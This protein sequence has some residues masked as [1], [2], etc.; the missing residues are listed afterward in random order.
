[1]HEMSLAG[2][3]LKLVEDAALREGFGRV[4]QLRLEAGKLAGVEL[5][6]LLFALEV[7]VRGTCLEGAQILIDEPPGQG[8]CLNCAQNVEVHE[9]GQPCPRCGG[10]QLMTNGGDRLRVVDMQVL[11]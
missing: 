6:A 11:D 3:I 10:W 5:P 1:M 8:W 2:G 4:S 9:R 7:V